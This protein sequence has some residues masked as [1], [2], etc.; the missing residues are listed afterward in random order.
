MRNPR[1]AHPETRDVHGRAILAFAG[2]L[3]I[4]VCLVLA[5]VRLFGQAQPPLAFGAGTG[6]FASGQPVLQ[7]DTAAD[8]AVYEAEKQ[9]LLAST[10]WVDRSAGIAHIPIDEAIRMIA[11]DG[12]P[13]WGQRPD[14]TAAGCSAVIESVPRAPASAGCMGAAAPP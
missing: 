11:A 5:A 2:G 10:Y 14:A 12:V 8:R 9:A 13:D 1:I 7:V 6:L 3:L 4:F